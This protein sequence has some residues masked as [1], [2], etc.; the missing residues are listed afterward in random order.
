MKVLYNSR[1]LSDSSVSLELDD[2]AFCYGDGLFETIVTGPNR[3]N[4]IEFHFDRLKRGCQ[5]L[6]LKM[7]LLNPKELIIRIDQLAKENEIKGTIR[8]KLQVW[9][10]SGGLYAP[11]NNESN[12]LLTVDNQAGEFYNEITSISDSQNSQLVYSNISGLKTLNALPYILAGIEKNNSKFEDLIIKNEK[13]QIVEMIASN[14]FWIKGSTIYT[15]SL[16]SGCVEGVMRKYLL[17]EFR[18][19]NIDCQEILAETNDLL[20]AQSIFLTNASGINWVKHYKTI[21]LEDPK[22]FLY[23]SIKLQQLL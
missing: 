23:Q 10:Q 5:K 12:Y 3:L 20:D 19:K 22:D 21:E 17:S 4:L 8:A 14:I 16:K 6:A 1:L 9:R 15:P 13:D 2:R 18:S 7:P 11:K